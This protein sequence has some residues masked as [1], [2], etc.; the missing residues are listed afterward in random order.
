MRAPAVNSTVPARI[1]TSSAID[2]FGSRKISPTSG[3]RI[4]RN[5]SRPRW[6]VRICSPFFAA[7]M[8]VHTTAA[9]LASSDG[10]TVTTPRFTQRRAPLM[11]GAMRCVN[12]SSGMSNSSAVTPSSGQA[13]RRQT[14]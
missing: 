2:K 3:P 8:A 14:W 6:N 1:A 5:G 10:C 9:S 7:S 11:V 13:A 12:G 4:T